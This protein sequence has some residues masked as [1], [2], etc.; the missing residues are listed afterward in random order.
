[1]LFLPLFQLASVAYAQV[2][3]TQTKRANAAACAGEE[4]NRNASMTAEAT[5]PQALRPRSI[6][7]HAAAGIASAASTMKNDGEV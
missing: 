5:M 1:M 2:Q 6:T 4:P 7:P 3:A